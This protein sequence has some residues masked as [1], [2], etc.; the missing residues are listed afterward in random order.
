MLLTT[1]QK[2]TKPQNHASCR[3]RNR[4]RSTAIVPCERTALER[5]TGFNPEEVAGNAL[6]MKISAEG[7]SHESGAKPVF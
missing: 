7:S 6:A 5:E 1:A 3:N 2:C 4:N